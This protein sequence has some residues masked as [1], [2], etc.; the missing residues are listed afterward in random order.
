MAATYYDTLLEEGV[1][2]TIPA[3]GFTFEDLF[4]ELVADTQ[5]KWAHDRKKSVGASEAF[6][7]IRKT[8]FGKRGADFGYK[9]DPEYKESW[10]AMR[11]GDLIENYHVVPAV[12]A[13]LRRRGLKLILA[14]TGQDTILDGN[15]SATLDGLILSEE[16]GAKLPIDFLAYYGIPEIDEESVVFEIKSFDPRINIMEEKAIHGG[17]VQ[18]QM[19]LIR[20]TTNYKPNYAVILYVNASWLDDLRPFVVK[21]D[22]N[23]YQLGR[24][25]AEKVF[26]IDDPALLGAEGKLDGMCTYCPFQRSCAKVST[27]RV[28]PRRETLKKKE[29]EGQ[30]PELLATLDELVVEVASLKKAKKEVEKELEDANE[31]VRQALI[32]HRESRAVG[33]GWK[34][35]YTTVAGR[36]TL[37]ADK[38]IEAGLIPDDYMEEGA[39]Y[40]KLTVT[41]EKELD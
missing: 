37:S 12:E 1:P 4:D 33:S 28:P 29:I 24:K 32:Q 11:R 23:V 7:C 19:G 2:E 38:M 3:D 41:L 9:K 17:Q 8:W 15:S 35:S 16:Q 25:R 39:G 18:M 31:A 20:E 6:G 10:G 14:G 26:N 21:F 30:D 34:V 27:D 5:K 13:G 22:E 40:E 36:K